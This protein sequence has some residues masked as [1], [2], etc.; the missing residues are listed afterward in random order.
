MKKRHIAI[1]PGAA[2][3]I[4]IVVVLAMTM[5]GAMALLNAREDMRLMRRSA[6]ADEEIY[7]LYARAERSLAALDA[8]AG[9]GADG[10]ATRL[11]EGMTLMEDGATVAWTEHEGARGLQCEAEI[12]TEN[13]GA[14][15]TWRAQRLLSGVEEIWN[16]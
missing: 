1:G 6:R 13:G 11:P 8:A 10:L 9:Q 5:L 12:R 4:L 7:A 3:L 2:S 16:D 14:S 15:V